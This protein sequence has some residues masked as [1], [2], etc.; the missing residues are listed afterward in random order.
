MGAALDVLLG[1][2]LGEGSRWRT[3]VEDGRWSEVL[4]TTH[5][6]FVGKR[7]MRNS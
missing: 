7:T 3:D 1:G 5:M 6:G 4:N 2:P